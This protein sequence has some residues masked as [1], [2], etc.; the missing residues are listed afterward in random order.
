MKMMKLR[1]LAALMLVLMALMPHA[2]ADIS[3]QELFDALNMYDMDVTQPGLAPEDMQALVR[4]ADAALETEYARYQ[5]E[6]YA[7]DGCT[8]Y[9]ALRVTPLAPDETLLMSGYA[10]DVDDPI[11]ARDG[12]STGVTFAEAAQASGRRIVAGGFDADGLGKE[13]INS[14]S[15]WEAFEDDGSMLLFGRWTYAEPTPAARSQQLTI[16]EYQPGDERARNYQMQLELKPTVALERAAGECSVSAGV[17]EV[18]G[19][20]VF[21]SP[22]GMF[23]YVDCVV[24]GELSA[25]AREELTR[26]CG[27][28]SDEAGAE[29]FMLGGGACAVS[30]GGE[31]RYSP[32]EMQ[33]GDRF[34][35]E[36]ELAAGEGLPGEVQ[37]TLY[38]YM[39]EFPTYT[40][41]VPLRAVN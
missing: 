5:V 11:P 23:A 6:L 27:T 18:T 3:A 15:Y 7:F 19:V 20:R 38:D 8:A 39:G 34:W 17:L 32:D 37:V 36:L 12:S 41:A 22:L 26:I 9:V 13:L 14:T 1:A 29:L 30:P 10:F 35:F 21:R 24:A 40:A 4:A 2:L 28:L 16:R 25:A 33:Q 31:K